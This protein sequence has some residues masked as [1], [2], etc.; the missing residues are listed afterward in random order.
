MTSTDS[1]TK[2]ICGHLK[3]RSA[4]AEVDETRCPKDAEDSDFVI[5][6]QSHLCFQ[7]KQFN[8]DSIGEALMKP[9]IGYQDFII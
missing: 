7:I 1:Q 6:K 2:A 8:K 5:S 3:I 9:F 4:Y